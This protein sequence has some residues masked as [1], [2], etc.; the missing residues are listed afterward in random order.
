MRQYIVN[1][2]TEE[3]FGGSPV[4]VCIVESWISSSDM[5]KIAIQNNLPET[6]FII[7]RG[8][9]YEL[10]CFSPYGEL[11][12]FVNS[13]QAAAY[14]L[15]RF[16]RPELREISFKT[17]KVDIKVKRKYDKIS[18]SIPQL[19]LLELETSYEVEEAL[20]I[21]PKRIFAGAGGFFVF[22]NEEDVINFNPD[23]DKIVELFNRA[24]SLPERKSWT[25][26]ID[27][28][29]SDNVDMR[30]DLEEKCVLFSELS[31]CITSIS[32][33]ADCISRYFSLGD[34]VTHGYEYPI[35]YETMVPYWFGEL[36][37][38]KILIKQIDARDALLECKNVFDTKIEISGKA[39]LY[40]ISDIYVE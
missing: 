32:E 38:D 34:Y 39:R 35:K 37:K 23:I 36:K 16:L 19:K 17:A 29:L 31:F 8:I 10:R 21:M 24:Y 6:A 22:E 14:V 33:E 20:G 27:D 12:K 26:H 5:M 30:M 25:R 28:L 7:N 1:T 2:F 40:A 11:Y 3:V 13:S 9:Y 18:V 15:F 4:A